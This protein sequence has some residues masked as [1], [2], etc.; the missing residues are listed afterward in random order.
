MKVKNYIDQKM[1]ELTKRYMSY[2]DVMARLSDLMMIVKMGHVEVN[3]DTLTE[4]KADSRVVGIILAN[5]HMIHRLELF[6][7]KI[8]CNKMDYSYAEYRRR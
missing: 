4:T 8:H 2:G 1:A 3:V 6:A 5:V 7:D